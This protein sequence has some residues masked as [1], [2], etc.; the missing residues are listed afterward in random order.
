VPLVR[1]AAAFSAGP[2]QLAGQLVRPAGPG[3]FPAVVVVPGSVRATRDSYDLWTMFFAS[4]GFAVLSYDRPG[5]GASTGTYVEAAT[6][7]NLQLLAGVAAAGVAWLAGQREI[8]RTR[9]GLTGGS[10]AGWTIPLAASESRG[11]AFAA[12]QS[13]PAMSV[14]R[15]LAYAEVTL[16]GGRVP[17][18][19]PAE[20]RSAL[21]GVPDSG[22]DPR[23]A[24]QALTIPILWQLGAV[25]KRMYTPETVANLRAIVAAGRH[26]YTIDVYPHAAHSLRLAPHGLIHEEAVSPGFAPH[27][28]SD[29]AVWLGQR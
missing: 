7:Q 20:V 22:Y 1:Q 26:D 11:V 14:G 6:D 24:L 2:V 4:Q 27:V 13:G 5:V 28:F 8:D 21:A 3:P 15:Q 9:I 25:D 19:T 17:P 10:Q 12:V 23:P 29:L 16:Q 18:P